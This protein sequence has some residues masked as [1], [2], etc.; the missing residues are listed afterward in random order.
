MNTFYIV[1][2]SEE[3]EACSEANVRRRD[4]LTQLKYS[5]RPIIVVPTNIINGFSSGVFQ[6]F[7]R[8][9]LVSL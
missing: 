5:L 2:R 4:D 3:S 8:T 7:A 6:S 1:T 9:L